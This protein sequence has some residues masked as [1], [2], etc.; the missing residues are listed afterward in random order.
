MFFFFVARRKTLLCCQ[1]A[2]YNGTG[3]KSIVIRKFLSFLFSFFLGEMDE[4]ARLI[5]QGGAYKVSPKCSRMQTR[6]CSSTGSVSKRV[7]LCTLDVKPGPVTTIQ[8]QQK[9]PFQV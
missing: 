5:H 6:Q 2:L 1:A 8:F 3:T 9:T 7:L 4:G